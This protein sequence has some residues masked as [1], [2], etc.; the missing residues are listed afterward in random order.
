MQAIG[1]LSAAAAAEIFYF[2][3]FVS[4]L[5]ALIRSKYRNHEIVYHLSLPLILVYTDIQHSKLLTENFAVGP[6]YS[7]LT[8]EVNCK[9]SYS[10]MSDWL[11][12][13]GSLNVR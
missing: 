5:K 6:K 2:E 8:P 1:L 10:K 3:Q 7:N 11:H 9:I 12:F 4:S 13:N